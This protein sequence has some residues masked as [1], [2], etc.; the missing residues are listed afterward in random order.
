MRRLLLVGAGPAHL[1]VLRHLAREPLAAGEALLVAP[2][3]RPMFSP[4]FPACVDGRRTAEVCTLP[5][6]ALAQAAHVPLVESSVVALDAAGRR[7]TLADGRV[8][9]YDGLS[10]DDLGVVDRDRLPGARVH[11]LFARPH[12]AFAS[13]FGGLLDLASTRVLDGRLA[14]WLRRRGDRRAFDAC[15]AIPSTGR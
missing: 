13:L 1:Q 3:P 9:E 4:W 14:G 12:A 5:L 10:L 6:P 15:S 7:A 8:A 11:A 2:N